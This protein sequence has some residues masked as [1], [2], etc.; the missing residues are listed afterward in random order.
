[1]TQGGRP[2]REAIYARLAREVRE[3]HDRLGGL[4]SPAE[5]GDIWTPLWHQ[6]AHNSTALEGNTLLL[7]EVQTL[8]LEGRAVGNKELKDYL[9]VKGYAAAAEWVYGRALEPGN[10]RTEELVTLTEVRETH[11]RLMGAVWEVV[12]HPDALPEESPGNWRRHDIHPFPGGMTPPSFADIQV[13]MSDWVGSVSQLREDDRPVAEAVAARHGAFERIHPFI[14]GNG[15]AGRLLLNLILVRLGYPPAII[16]KRD[17]PRYLRALNQ[18][19]RGDPGALGE[20]IARAIL[21]NLYRFVVPAVA[22]PARLVPIASLSSAEVT[23]RALRAAA[24]RGR[25][26]AVRGDD[27]QWRSTRRWLDDYVRS[28]QH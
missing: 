7:R 12:P 20:L 23:E 11:R 21:D 6:E 28:R 3:L 22:G 17:R 9:E 18:A 26:R 1:M 14:D 13:L 19:D 8:L 15:R 2:R 16:R 10:W 24:Q 5:A 27:G 25:L 4:P